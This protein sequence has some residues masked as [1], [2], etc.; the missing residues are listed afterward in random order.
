MALGGEQGIGIGPRHQPVGDQHIENLGEAQPVFVGGKVAW[1]DMEE[2][3]LGKAGNAGKAPPA[4]IPLPQSGRV[5]VP[6]LMTPERA[7]VSHLTRLVAEGAEAG[8]VRAPR[9]LPGPRSGPEAAGLRLVRGYPAPAPASQSARR[10]CNARCHLR[11]TA[12][13]A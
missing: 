7:S 11:A 5:L 12:G 1:L 3:R 4:R 2:H 10:R 9:V 6:A 13:P 8:L